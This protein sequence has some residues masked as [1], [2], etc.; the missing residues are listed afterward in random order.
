[1]LSFPVGKFEGVLGLWSVS[2]DPLLQGK[3][4]G[5]VQSWVEGSRRPSFSGSLEPHLGGTS[6]VEVPW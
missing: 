4:L 1:M 6:G 3:V 5:T 2:L